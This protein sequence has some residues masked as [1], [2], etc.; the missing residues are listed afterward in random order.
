MKRILT[1]A[2][3]DSGGGAGIQADLKAITLLGGF[4]M[5]AITALTA[6]NTVG[7]QGIHEV[8]PRFVEEQID[9]VLSDIGADAIK[10]GMLANREIIEVVSRKIK[11]YKVKRVVVD[12]VMI[13]KSGASLLRKDAQETLVRRLIPV[14]WV[15][16]PNLMEASALAG[17]RVSSLGGMKKAARRIY[18]MGTKYVVVKGGHLKG[19]AVDLLYDGERFSEIEGPRIESKNTHGTGCTFASAIATFLARGDTVYEAVRKAKTFITLAIQSG[20]RLGKGTSP[21]NPSAYVLREMERYRVIQVLKKAV[22]FLKEEKVGHLIPE[23]SSNLGYALPFAEE[24]EDVAAFPGRIFRFKDSVATYRDPEFGASRHIANIILTVMKVDP[25]YCSAMNIRYSRETVAQLKRKGF[26]VGQFD[27]RLEP[28]GV[29]AKEGSSLEWG[30]GD[31]LR[32]MKR[33]P[34]FIFDEGNMGKEPMIRVLGKNPLEVVQKVLKV[35][36]GK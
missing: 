26:L 30:A 22:E 16:T 15:V 27:R 35:A 17:F 14:A 36:S 10:T 31:V 2:G 23:V 18:R 7:V 9:A 25:E 29:K 34:D 24:V 19:V 11:Q 1:I 12:P 32:T 28:K 20:F 13:S 5:S 8:P 3:S 6:Q 33:V 21:T 4:G